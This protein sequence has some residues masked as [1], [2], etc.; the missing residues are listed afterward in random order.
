MPLGLVLAH[1]REPEVDAELRRHEAE[2][3]RLLPALHPFYRNAGLSLAAALRGGGLAEAPRAA[4]V[5]AFARDWNEGH[6]LA[7][8]TRAALDAMENRQRGH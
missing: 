6:D 3:G 4:L 1:A 2:L 8:A 7:D 5:A